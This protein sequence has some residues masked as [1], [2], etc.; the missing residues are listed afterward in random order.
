MASDV[1]EREDLNVPDRFEMLRSSGSGT[2]R[3]L[4]LPVTSSLE[5]LDERFMD[6]RAARRGGMTVLRGEPGAGKSTFLDTVHLFRQNVTT[7]RLMQDDDIAA[8]LSGLAPSDHPRIVVV[9]GREA[10][11]DVSEAALEASMHAINI[12]ARHQHVRSKT[13]GFQ[14]SRSVA[15]EYRSVDRVPC[16]ARGASRR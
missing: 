1:V 9:E 11:L 8:K 7:E 4:I 12:N 10:L 16:G 13:C 15:H 14:Y 3:S 5:D 2:L 6:L